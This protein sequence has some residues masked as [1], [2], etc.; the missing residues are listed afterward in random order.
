MKAF[1]RL[2]R[3]ATVT[4]RKFNHKGLGGGYVPNYVP[5]TLVLGLVARSGL[6]DTVKVP[7]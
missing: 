1:S 5:K 6:G 2:A 3:G 4:T 7:F